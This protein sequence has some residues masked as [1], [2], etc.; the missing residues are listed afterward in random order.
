MCIFSFTDDYAYIIMGLIKWS[1]RPCKVGKVSVVAFRIFIFRSILIMVNNNQ[2]KKNVWLKASIT[3]SSGLDFFSFWWKI[4]QE[5]TFPWWIFTQKS[6]LNYSLILKLCIN[7]LQTKNQINTNEFSF[8]QTLRGV[9]RHS[10][11][12]MVTRFY[13]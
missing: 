7:P 10:F 3:G 4:Q 12:T 13:K 2:K 5:L 11:V 6:M 8:K 9:N 1:K